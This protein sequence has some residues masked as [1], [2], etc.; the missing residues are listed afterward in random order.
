MKW[1]IVILRFWYS[2]RFIL[3]NFYFSI[4]INLL[5]YVVLVIVFFGMFI[6]LCNVDIL[7]FIL[8]SFYGMIV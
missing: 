5:C 3:R 2:F 6:Y 4:L 1:N 7:F 8:D